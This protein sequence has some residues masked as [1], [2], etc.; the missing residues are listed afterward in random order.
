MVDA[1]KGTYNP[2]SSEEHVDLAFLIL[3]YG[4]P[5][6]LDIVHKAMNFPCTST[7]YRLLKK[8]HEIIKSSVTTEMDEF[9]ENINLDQKVPSHGHMLKV[10]ETYA[11]PKARWNPQDNKMYGLCY[12]H[13]R[14][15][16]LQFTSYEHVE[17]LAEMVKSGEIHTPKETMVIATSS[18]F[19]HFGEFQDREHVH[20]LH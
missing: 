3:Q 15:L 12:E 6:L 1:I 17:Q 5:G 2:R 14:E 19:H 20:Q 8:S 11:E 18:N 10:D 13:C 9:I 4:G 7:A 16:D